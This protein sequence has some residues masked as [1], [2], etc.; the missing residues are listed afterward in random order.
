MERQSDICNHGRICFDHAV[1][2]EVIP[3]LSKLVNKM[4]SRLL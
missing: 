4:S 2:T 1:L 3:V